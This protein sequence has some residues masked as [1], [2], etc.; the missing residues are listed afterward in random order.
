[1]ALMQ[2]LGVKIA[3]KNGKGGFYLGNFAEHKDLITRVV[4][5]DRPKAVRETIIT[6]FTKI[7]EGT[8]E[9]TSVEK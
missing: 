6:L 8:A 9:V 2:D 5:S 3:S 7:D 4:G 1:M